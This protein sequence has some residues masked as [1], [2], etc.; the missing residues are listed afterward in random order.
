MQPL[1][2]RHHRLKG[3]G[4]VTVEPVLDAD[5]P[6]GTLRWTSWTGQEYLHRPPEAAVAPL[7]R[8]ERLGNSWSR[9]LA[10]V[11]AHE[12]CRQERATSDKEARRAPSND[13]PLF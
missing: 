7:R 2:R 1:C 6:V 8:E 13:P 4:M 3:T 9:S 5:E 11:H 12:P 10:E